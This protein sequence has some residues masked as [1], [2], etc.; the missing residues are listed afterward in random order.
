MTSEPTQD[1]IWESLY[2]ADVRARYFA[3]VAARLRNVERYLALFVAVASSGA[4]VSI[5]TKVPGAPLVLTLASA[6][7][8][9][10]LATFKVDKRANVSASLARQWLEIASEY[11]VLWS[12]VGE[13]SDKAALERHRELERKH[14]PADELAVSEFRLNR[15]LLDACFEAVRQR[16]GL[17]AAAA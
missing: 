16:H 12:R 13:I 6:L 8:A 3:E 2:M 14:F 9:A 4:A 7:A 5:L 1:L 10:V 15:R 17:G 11:Q